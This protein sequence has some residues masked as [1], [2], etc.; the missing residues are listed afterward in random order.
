MTTITISRQLGCGGKDVATLICERLGFRYFDK[1]L[2]T[3]LGA[4]LGLAPEQI[5]DLPEHQHRVKSLVE[6]LFGATINPFGDPSGW[7]IPAQLEAQQRTSVQTF[8]SLIQAA[9]AH[10]DVV[11]MGRGGQAVLHNTPGVLHVR[12]VAPLEQRIERVRQREELSADEARAR[13]IE[14]DAASFDYVRRFYTVDATD[15]LLYDM[16]INTDHLPLPSVADLIV[17]ALEALPASA[18]L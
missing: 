18:A 10:G 9:H 1:E 14:R 5:V 7:T 6:R 2:M 8:Q 11:I 4:E 17:R 16:V 13:I 15:P 12:L 3:Q